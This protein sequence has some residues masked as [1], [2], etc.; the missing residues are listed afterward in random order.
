MLVSKQNDVFTCEEE[1][2]IVHLI[3]H[4]NRLACESSLNDRIHVVASAGTQLHQ[5]ARGLEVE[6]PTCFR[7]PIS[8]G[9]YTI[10][11]SLGCHAMSKSLG[12]LGYFK[13][14]Q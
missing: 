4:C 1:T 6:P 2:V 11:K 10:R 8:L 12:F 9:S 7:F 3:Q 13:G 5:L 14:V